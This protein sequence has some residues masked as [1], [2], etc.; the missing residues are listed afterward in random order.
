MQD[1]ADESS[2]KKLEAKVKSD[3][4]RAKSLLQ[5]VLKATRDTASIVHKFKKALSETASKEQLARQK[6]E[7]KN[8]AAQGKRI[9]KINREVSKSGVPAWFAF[10]GEGVQPLRAFSNLADLKKAVAENK[11]FQRG[12]PYVITI[13]SIELQSMLEDPVCKKAW[14]I[15]KA[16]FPEQ[17]QAVQ[18][19]RAQCKFEHPEQSKLC[20]LLALHFPE[21][22]MDAKD[23]RKGLPS[24]DTNG[25]IENA[26]LQVSSFGYT[27]S[28]VWAGAEL[29]CLSNGRFQY[30]GERELVVCR[31][32][33]MHD[34]LQG[35]GRL[36]DFTKSEPCLKQ[37]SD[38]TR[39]NVFCVP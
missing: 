26:L 36:T 32:S 24:E 14:A 4:A 6:E 19:G 25:M 7:K 20:R 1:M 12:D 15:F 35:L 9:S 3:I 21:N 8:Q 18:D 37:V 2:I 31:F 38:R 30:K 27:E 10:S 5:S 28:M 17:P 22:A 29:N 34:F 16:R 33:D 23:I 11:D 13:C 39:V